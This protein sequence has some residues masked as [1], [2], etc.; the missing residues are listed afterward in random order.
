MTVAAHRMLAVLAAV[1][2]AALGDAGAQSGVAYGQGCAVTGILRGFRPVPVNDQGR[3]AGW[4]DP[5]AGRL[6]AVEIDLVRRSSTF[7]GYER[8]CLDQPQH[9]RLVAHHREA[10]I[11]LRL[12]GRCMTGTE[13]LGTRPYGG[14][15]PAFATLPEGQLVGV[16]AAPAGACA[17]PA[18]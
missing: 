11:L 17:T 4:F 2:V 6:L 12:K 15:L 3:P 7:G 1:F 18:R 9:L 13:G 5:I 8:F 14:A 10:P 16:T